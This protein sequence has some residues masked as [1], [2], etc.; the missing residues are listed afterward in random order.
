M[1]PA[2][3]TGTSAEKVACL[4][5]DGD[6]LIYFKRTDKDI[7]TITPDIIIEPSF[8]DFENGKDPVFEWILKQ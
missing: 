1:L 2:Q 7:K 3:L 8:P 5:G 4:D 6:R